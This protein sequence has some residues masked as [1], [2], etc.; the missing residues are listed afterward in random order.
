LRERG[1]QHYVGGDR[2][3][4][5]RVA[6]Q[7]LLVMQGE[8]VLKSYPCSTALAGTGTRKGSLKTPLG[9]HEIAEMIGGGLPAGAILRSRRWTG[10][11]WK[12]GDASDEDLILSRILRP[13]G[14]EEGVNRGGDVDTR[15]RLI[16]IHGTNAEEELGRPV[17]HG[18]VRLSNDAVVEL[19][20]VVDVGCRIL[21]TAE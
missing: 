6:G 14:L 5:V 7:R 11:I 20:D 12:A 19:F 17:S 2:G 4:W 21:I 8:R 10:D 9:W 3:I 16:Y 15:D 13:A 18:C 1:W